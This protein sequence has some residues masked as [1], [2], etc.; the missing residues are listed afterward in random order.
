[1]GKSEKFYYVYS[2]L[3]MLIQVAEYVS[4]CGYLSRCSINSLEKH[5]LW[6][7]LFQLLF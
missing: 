5:G 2:A 1:M 3:S 6:G 4:L 7:E